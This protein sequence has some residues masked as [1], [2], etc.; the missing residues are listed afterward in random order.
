MCLGSILAY[1]PTSSLSPSEAP[2]LRSDT[3]VGFPAQADGYL[4]REHLLR[5]LAAPLAVPPDHQVRALRSKANRQTR[6]H[7]TRPFTVSILAIG[8]AQQDL[9]LCVPRPGLPRVRF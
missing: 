7:S 3:D 2:S 4:P 5:Q 1:R 8:F 6:L 9:C